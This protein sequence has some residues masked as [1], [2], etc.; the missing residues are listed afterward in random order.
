MNKNQTHIKIRLSKEEKL[1]F[2]GRAM[3]YFDGNL[4]EFVRHCCTHF[5]I[6]KRKK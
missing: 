4:S 3:A 2:E 6:K 1:N 5:K